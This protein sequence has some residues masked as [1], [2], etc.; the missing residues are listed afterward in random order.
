MDGVLVGE[1]GSITLF[2]YKTDRLSYAEKKDRA[3]AEKKLLDRHRLQL[4][5]YIAACRHIF[6]KTP[7][8]VTIY[9][10]A[11]GDTVDLPTEEFGESLKI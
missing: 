11:L 7:D 4:G 5:Y 3:L 10:L 8:R 2:D 1:D 9:S 6:G